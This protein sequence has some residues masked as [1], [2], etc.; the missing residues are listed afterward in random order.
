MTAADIQKLWA[1]ELEKMTVRLVPGDSR[2]FKR[3]LKK[4]IASTENIK[5]YFLPAVDVKRASYGVEIPEP[6]EDPSAHD[7]M[8]DEDDE[9]RLKLFYI[10]VEALPEGILARPPHLDF[11]YFRNGGTMTVTGTDEEAILVTL[12]EEGVEFGGEV[13]GWLRDVAAERVTIMELRGPFK[14][15]TVIGHRE[16]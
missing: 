3:M 1:D 9:P 12:Q 15:G 6:C 7:P 2:T 5:Q 11:R 16:F 4:A 10:T 13:G 8:M 14:H